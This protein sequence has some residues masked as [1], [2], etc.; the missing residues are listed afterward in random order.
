MEPPANVQQPSGDSNR[1]RNNPENLDS[2]QAKKARLSDDSSDHRCRKFFTFWERGETFRK[3]LPEVRFSVVSRS[4]KRL[5]IPENL[6]NTEK[7]WMILASSKNFASFYIKYI[8]DL[9]KF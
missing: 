6:T 4:I 3:F 9:C 7:F 2:G 5:N 8:D 1:K